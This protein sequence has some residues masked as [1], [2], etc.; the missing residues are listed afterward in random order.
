MTSKTLYNTFPQQYQSKAIDKFRSH[1]YPQLVS[2][3][4]DVLGNEQEPH[5]Y[6]V[7]KLLKGGSAGLKPNEL[8]HLHQTL[9]DYYS[10]NFEDG[11]STFEEE[12]IPKFITDIELDAVN[13]LRLKLHHFK[14][15]MES[16]QVNYHHEGMRLRTLHWGYMH[17]KCV[18]EQYQFVYE[19]TQPS[20]FSSKGGISLKS[21]MSVVGVKLE[22]TARELK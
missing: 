16:R 10:Y 13:H 15:S 14:R 21:L 17:C 1:F 18:D 8:Y 19:L 6:M 3:A 9:T 20:G 11:P 12:Y 22:L 2:N 7:Y 5:S 4:K